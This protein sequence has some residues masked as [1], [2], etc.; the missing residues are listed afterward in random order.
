MTILIAGII[1]LLGNIGGIG[2]G[3]GGSPVGW[4]VILLI[5]IQAYKTFSPGATINDPLGDNT[6][7][8]PL[9]YML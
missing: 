9:C 6:F 5:V 8:L 3:G 7:D 4:L 1:H 2:Q